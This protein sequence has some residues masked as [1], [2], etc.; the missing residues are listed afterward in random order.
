MSALRAALRTVTDKL[1]T[2]YLDGPEKKE[3]TKDDRD[4]Y[5]GWIDEMYGSIA[6]ARAIL[7]A[8]EDYAGVI[9]RR[10][11]GRPADR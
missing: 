6:K 11:A 3:R 4:R 7:N 8:T 5:S 9:E 10:R 1:E 2:L